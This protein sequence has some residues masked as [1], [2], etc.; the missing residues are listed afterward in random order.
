LEEKTLNT[1]ATLTDLR[2]RLGLTA[3]QTADDG[4]LLSYLVAASRLIDAYTGRHFYPVRETRFYTYQH[5]AQLLL[6]ADLLTLHTLSNGSIIPLDACHILPG[7]LVL[8][9]TQA[10]FTSGADPVDSISVTG[11]WGFHTDWERAWI[12]SDDSIQNNPLS[13]NILS[14]MVNDI[15]GMDLT[16]YQAR[17]AVGQL[18]RL[19]DEYVCVR[20]IAIDTNVLTVER[21]VNGTTAANHAQGTPIDVYQ[22][23]EDVKQACLRVA[24]WLYKQKDAGFVQAA[25]NLRGQMVVPPALPDDIQQIL[26]PYLR[27]RV[28]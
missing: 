15:D 27:I 26:A 28:A 20:A 19:E 5:A 11:L 25:G 7:V 6:D 10:V 17:F 3:S 16:G 18:L 24:S 8:D 23:P 2:H 14:V 22:P 21:G 4:L 12:A 9:Q 1:Y 13:A